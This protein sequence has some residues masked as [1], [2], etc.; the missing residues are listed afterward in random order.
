[1]AGDRHPT[2]YTGVRYRE[3]TDRKHGG[4]LDRYFFVRYK[5]N[6]KA[7]EEGLGWASEGMTAQR[8][9]LERAKLREAHRIGAGPETL[10]ERREER[11]V[12]KD[13]AR[14][15]GLTFE[16]L[17]DQYMQ[18][19]KANKK[20][21]S[22]DERRLQLHVLPIIGS[23]A[24]ADIGAAECEAVKVACQEKKLAPAT[25][26]HCLQL[27][28][29]LFNHAIRWNLFNGANPTKGIK[30]IKHDNRRTRFLSYDEAETLL[31]TIKE[32]SQDWHDITLVALFAGLRFGEIAALTW[33][34][35][36]LEHGVINI[37][38]AKS[39]EGRPAYITKR[40]DD[41]LRRRREETESHLV[42]PGRYG[43]VMDR[44]SRT[45]DRCINDLG[46]N[47]GIKDRRQK[48]TFHTTRHTFGSWLAIQGTPLL[49]IKELIGHKTIEMTMRYAH[50]I[51][52]QKRDAVEELEKRAK[53]KVLP[54]IK[55]KGM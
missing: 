23:M 41:M 36:D 24:L 20:S 27:I 32:R 9:H 17:A 8:A 54:L 33:H 26:N 5:A 16:E 6:G 50:L 49:T 4:R 34:D 40:L 15:Q 46:W 2:K 35:V 29:S 55:V 19:A 47:D 7:I 45:I 38:D 14:R 28:R 43:E 53:A 11:Q 39:G 42:F 1:M 21:W 18:W 31:L 13:E 48:V 10:K 22:H 51:P 52:D 44:V 25:V 30:L 3:H 12:K 37:R